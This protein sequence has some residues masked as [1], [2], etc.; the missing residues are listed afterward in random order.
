MASDPNSRS[1]AQIAVDLARLAKAIYNIIRAAAAAG[2]KGAA[3]AA[4]K[5]SLPILIKV[6]AWAVFIL[7]I[8]PMLI[9]ASLPNIF[10][11]YG[12]SDTDAVI[13]M[14]EQ[15]L[16]IGGAYM[17]LDE[18]ER[19]QVDS[20]ITSLVAE[21]EEQG[22]DIDEI[23]VKNNMDDEDLMWIIAINSAAHQQDLNTMSV[24]S[25]REF[26]STHLFV[27]PTLGLMDGGDDGEMTILTISVDHIDPER[28]MDDLGFNEDAKTWAGAL[29]ETL[30]ESDAINK[31]SDYFAAYEPDYSGDSTWTGEVEHG[32]S[33]DNEIDI[34]GFV[35]PETK[36]NLDL[37]AY[38]I[39]AWENNWG[40]V[41]GTY[42]NVLTQSLFDY[43]LEQ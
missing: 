3:V 26:C 18:F 22:T 24:E 29:Y 9:L 31:Y 16:T 4:V 28:L 42:G 27:S 23:E 14:T 1:G 32:S 17:N 11:G 6:A 40:Y 20:L 15:A 12:S 33:Y 10:F 34:S 8:L 13:D 38:A 25:V 37:A 35:S 30:S 19:A 7:V 21:Y 5:E 43:K 39:Q 36:N 41:W 2:L